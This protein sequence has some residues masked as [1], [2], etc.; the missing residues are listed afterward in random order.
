MRISDW[1]SD[2]CSSDLEKAWLDGKTTFRKPIS[3][4]LYPIRIT[5][6][7]EFDLLNYDR[8]SICSPACELG[9]ELK[10][11]VY[12]FLKEALIRKYGETWYEGLEQSAQRQESRYLSE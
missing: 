1:S 8:W 9:A 12:R 6:Y 4:H 7:P 2:V 3:C 11:P 5:K 10:V